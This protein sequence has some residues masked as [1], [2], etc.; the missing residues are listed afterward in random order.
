MMD[1]IQR[2]KT[3]VREWLLE[4]SDVLVAQGVQTEMVA[5]N[6]DYLRII[7][8]TEDRMGEIVVEDASFAPYRFFKIEVAQI[9]DERAKIVMAWYD[10][11]TTGDDAYR[12]ALKK[13]IDTLIHIGE[14]REKDEEEVSDYRNCCVVR[15]RSRCAE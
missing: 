14:E 7:L 8:E 13:G 11:D 15:C 3:I 1:R 10:K 9:V 12:E 5:D 6:E 4:H 2:V